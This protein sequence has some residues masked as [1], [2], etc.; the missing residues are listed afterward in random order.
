MLS[1]FWYTQRTPDY[2]HCA[3]LSMLLGLYSNYTSQNALH[4][5]IW[6]CWLYQW[7]PLLHWLACHLLC[8]WDTSAALS[9]SNDVSYCKQI[10]FFICWKWVVVFTRLSAASQKPAEK[11]LTKM[12]HCSIWDLRYPRLYFLRQTRDHASLKQICHDNMSETQTV[13]VSLSLTAHTII[14]ILRKP[15]HKSQPDT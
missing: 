13:V 12:Q 1:W 5:H 11:G 7:P 14:N 9:L 4:D 15:C 8:C 2:L 6:G 3:L 10:T